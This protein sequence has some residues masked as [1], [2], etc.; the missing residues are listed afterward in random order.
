M[1]WVL[2]EGLVQG[3]VGWCGF[4]RERDIEGMG[5]RFLIQRE[6]GD[7]VRGKEQR[8]QGWRGVFQCC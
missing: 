3:S 7:G 1:A 6:V 4:L 8:I 5:R 2:A